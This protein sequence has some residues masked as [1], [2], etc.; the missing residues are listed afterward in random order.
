MDVLEKAKLMEA[1]GEE[2][3]HLEVGEPDFPTPE[4]VTE[5]AI[6]ALRKQDTH[7]THSL[8]KLELR[9]EIAA[10]YWRKFRVE[11]S[12]EQILVSSGTSPAML[13]VF[14]V[15]LEQGREAIIPNPYYACYPN[16]IRF[17]NTEP[18]FVPLMKLM[19]L[20]CIQQR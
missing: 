5:A 7:Y 6:K 19:A 17:L 3:I 18:V 10:Y 16:F 8:G 9:E 14:S 12:P 4:P 20:N 11:I 13:L 2:I 1:E 15:L